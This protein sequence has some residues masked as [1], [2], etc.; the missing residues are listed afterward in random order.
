MFRCLFSVPL[1]ST[2][3]LMMRMAELVCPLLTTLKTGQVGQQPQGGS[4]A[5]SE[6]LGVP[7]TV[8]CLPPAMYTKLRGNLQWPC[9][10]AQSPAWSDA[11][12]GIS[13]LVPQI[14]CSH[15]NVPHKDGAIVPF[16]L[17]AKPQDMI[18]LKREMHLLVLSN[19][20][21]SAPSLCSS[22]NLWVVVASQHPPLSVRVCVGARY[23][24]QVCAAGGTAMSC[25]G[26]NQQRPKDAPSSKM[27]TPH[28]CM[29][30]RCTHTLC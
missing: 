4:A 3:S 11:V 21:P 2:L 5:C 28:S 22:G 18:S 6:E 17:S 23:S 9:A 19:W 7:G 1:L 29:K 27:L 20:V 8:W 30:S 26:V 24:P 25:C 14:S 10:E 15:P 16:A 13:E 12:H